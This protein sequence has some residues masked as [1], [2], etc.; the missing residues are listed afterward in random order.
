MTLIQ[1]FQ[2]KRF[3]H[4]MIDPFNFLILEE[5]LKIL[6]SNYNEDIGHVD[7]TLIGKNCQS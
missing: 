4:C 7:N 6:A 1:V 2:S 3:D 5:F